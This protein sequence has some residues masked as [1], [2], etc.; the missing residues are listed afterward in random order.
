MLKAFPAPDFT[1][2]LRLMLKVGFVPRGI[3]TETRAPPAKPGDIVTSFVF[4]A[5][6]NVT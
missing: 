2:E 4:P 1:L 6:V 5:A 3:V